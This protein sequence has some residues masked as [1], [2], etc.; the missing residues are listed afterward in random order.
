MQEDAG[1][2]KGSNGHGNF[3]LDQGKYDEALEAYEISIQLDPKS[4][5]RWYNKAQL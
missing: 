2:F 1:F 3:L 4:A 5:S